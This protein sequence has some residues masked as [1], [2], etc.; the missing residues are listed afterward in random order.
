ME[1][2]D[3]IIIGADPAG[4]SAGIYADYYGLRSIIFE[5]NIPGGLAVEIPLLEDYPGFHEGI[6]GR[7]LRYGMGRGL[8]RGPRDGR[9][10]GRGGGGRKG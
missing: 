8:G 6:S 10:A 1:H 4:L 5:E 2:R 9:G 3:L 7:G